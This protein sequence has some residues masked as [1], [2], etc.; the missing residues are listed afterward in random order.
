MYFSLK[1]KKENGQTLSVPRHPLH[2]SY[3]AKILN[4][5]LSLCFQMLR[6]L[7]IFYFFQSV[8][9]ETPQRTTIT[10]YFVEHFKLFMVRIPCYEG[11]LEAEASRGDEHGWRSKLW[12]IE[13]HERSIK[14]EEGVVVVL[15]GGGRER[16]AEG[17]SEVKDVEVIKEIEVIQSVSGYKFIST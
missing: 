15:Q 10:L 8:G 11:D 16:S 5:G 14:E 3:S 13:S 2:L 7:N 9:S 6:R 12:S 1:C 4:I 17:L